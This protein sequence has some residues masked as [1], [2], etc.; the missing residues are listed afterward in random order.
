[1]NNLTKG[2]ANEWYSWNLNLM[3]QVHNLHALVQTHP[4]PSESSPLCSS[5]FSRERETEP[6]ECIHTHTHVYALSPA[7]LRIYVQKDL[8]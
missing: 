2:T 6:I 8:L 5:G 4:A 7:P 3:A 1:M